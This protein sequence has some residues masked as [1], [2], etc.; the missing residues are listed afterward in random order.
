[1]ELATA[2]ALRA[3]HPG[4]LTPFEWGVYSACGEDGV[5]AEV[6]HRIGSGNRFAVEF[7][8]EDGTECNSR[9]LR[10]VRGWDVLQLDAEYGTP[11]AI[12]REFI[13]AE[14]VN[15]L[16]AKYHV[17][18]D[19]DFLCID[20][21]GNDFWVWKA[22]SSAYRPRL[23]LMEYNAIVPP[24]HIRVVSY[25]PGHVRNGHDDYFG[26][27]LLAMYLLARKK[28]YALV[29]CSSDGRNAFFVRQDLLGDHLI[30]K[31]PAEAYRSPAYGDQV[32][33]VWLGV[34]R[35][36]KEMIYLDLDLNP[37]G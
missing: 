26:G 35:S 31:Y 3:E 4:D 36:T 32:D 30:A 29:H 17:P 34:E 12:K 5:I 7:G 25:D 8:V 23:V 15:D 18:D 9:Y 16:F 22:L 1:M 27:S 33:G 14:N 21:D 20:I 11:P 37:V 2:D 19:L 10:E 6:F 13:T 28:G 24:C